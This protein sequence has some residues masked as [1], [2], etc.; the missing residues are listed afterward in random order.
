MLEMEYFVKSM[1]YQML[2]F[3]KEYPEMILR[4]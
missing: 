4:P 1:I 3:P 2:N